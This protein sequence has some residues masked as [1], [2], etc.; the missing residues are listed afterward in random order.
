MSNSYTVPD[1]RKWADIICDEAPPCPAQYKRQHVAAEPVPRPYQ[2]VKDDSL[3][4]RLLDIAT[5]FTADEA[6]KLCD[7]YASS[8]RTCIR[9]YPTRFR[10]ANALNS[11]P[12]LWRVVAD[13]AA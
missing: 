1:P 7:C 5:E 8:V 9:N 2:Y 4:A 12:A 3:L 11:G 13:A 10:R 6:A